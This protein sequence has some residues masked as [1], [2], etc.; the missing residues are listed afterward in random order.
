MAAAGVSNCL[1]DGASADGVLPPYLDLWLSHGSFR[2]GVTGS[3]LCMQ[4][5][6]KSAWVEFHPVGV[7]RHL[8]PLT[9]EG[10]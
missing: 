6:Y 10:I 3:P 1:E 2:Q 4:M 7:V 9:Q 5:F 8:L